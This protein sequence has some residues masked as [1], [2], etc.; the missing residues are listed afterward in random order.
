MVTSKSAK[1]KHTWIAGALIYSG[2][3]DPTWGVSARVVKKLQKLWESLPPAGEEWKPPSGRLGY[4]G[5][6]L[7]G[8]GN[9][10]WVACNGLVSLRTRVGMQVREDIARQF[11]K[12]LLS[13]APKGV[14]PQGLIEGGWAPS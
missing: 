14:L 3:P 12:T 1:K 9:R 4:R 5:S 8:T 7:R 2:R 6:F 10:E 13:S 11:E